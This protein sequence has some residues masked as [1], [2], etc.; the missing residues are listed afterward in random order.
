MLYYNLLLTHT[1]A[2]IAYLLFHTVRVGAM[3]FT[4][5]TRFDVFRNKTRILEMVL[6]TLFLLSGIYL[7][8]NH[9]SIF[10]MLFVIKL[11]LVFGCIPVAIIAFKRHTKWL[12][13]VSWLMLVM[14]YGMAEMSKKMVTSTKGKP[15]VD[16]ADDASTDQKMIA[17]KTLYTAY[18]VSCHGADGKLGMAGAKDLTA[19]ALTMDMMTDV[20]AHGRQAMPA[21][22]K[23]DKP[24]NKNQINA[25]AL[26]VQSLSK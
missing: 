24:L 5:A 15:I 17:G 16:V 11:V 23:N 3:L 7:L 26:Y 9:A 12:A 2:V 25:V 6:S 10:N 1:V 4:P 13:I 19:S 18:C 21:F 20:I 22:G 8:V 14:A